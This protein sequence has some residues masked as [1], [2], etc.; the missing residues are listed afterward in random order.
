MKIDEAAFIA[1]NATVAGNVTVERGGS[2]YFGAVIRTESEPIVVGEESNIQDNCVLHA[3]PGFPVTVGR[4]CTVG[5]GAILHGC[6]VGD[7]TLIGMGA[8]VLN[9][10]KIGKDCLVGAGAL[11]TQGAVIPDGSLVLGSPAGVK[12][13]LTPAEIDHN[14]YSAA[15]YLAE[16][17]AYERQQA[18]K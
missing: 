8:I 10:A 13:A 2:V 16:S 3:D 14:R 4:G 17:A 12:R 5:H 11:V 1:Q 18:A 7:N 9:G 15:L 6:T